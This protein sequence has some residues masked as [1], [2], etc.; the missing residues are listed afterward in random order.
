MN[1]RD[2]LYLQH[3]GVLLHRERLHQTLPDG[4]GA[5]GEPGTLDALGSTFGHEPVSEKRL[6]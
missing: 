6:P 5:S 4:V 3:T 1:G 2:A